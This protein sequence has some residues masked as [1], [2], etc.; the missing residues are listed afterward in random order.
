CADPTIRKTRLYKRPACARYSSSNAVA[1]PCRQR[2]ASSRST[3]LT[4]S[5]R[6][7]GGL[8][9]AGCPGMALLMTVAQT[10]SSE[11]SWS[12]AHMPRRVQGA[13]GSAALPA[14]RR[15]IAHPVQAHLNGL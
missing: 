14:D 1:S 8:V 9:G 4:S 7:D 12:Q 13:S 15:K 5:E 2:C 3:A 11:A 6:L 10:P